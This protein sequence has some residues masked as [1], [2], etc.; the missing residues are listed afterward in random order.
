MKKNSVLWHIV[1]RLSGMRM[2]ND[3]TSGVTMHRTTKAALR[4]AVPT[5]FA[6]IFFLALLPGCAVVGPLLSVGGMV[7]FAPLQY[8]S[9]AMTVGEYAYEYAAHDKDP[10]EVIEGKIMAVLDGSAFE[11]PDFDGDDEPTMVADG[12]PTTKAETVEAAISTEARKQRVEYL[13]AHRNL[14]FERLELRRMAFRRARSDGE[15][16]L[17]QTA[18]ASSPD[19]IR[20][21]EG[22]TTL[23]Q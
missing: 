9:T 3:S 16:S 4:K 1:I 18:M 17:R 10:S 11:M 13:L 21:A 8:A 12:A 2:V 5:T 14:Q 20:S 15:L 6:V 19:L 7:G 23:R 22:K